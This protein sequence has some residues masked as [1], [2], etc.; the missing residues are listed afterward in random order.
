MLIVGLD[1]ESTGVDPQE[2]EIIEV[3]AVLWDFETA[4]PLRIV[5]DLVHTEREITPEIT[6][7]TGISRS[8]LTDHGVPL[9]MAQ[10][11]LR[12]LLSFTSYVMAHFGNDFD[13]P[14]FERHIAGSWTPTIH[15]LDSATDIVYPCETRK[16]SYLAAEHNFLNPFAHRAVFD[17]L[18]MLRIASTYNIDSIIARAQEPTLYVRAIVSFDEKDKAKERGFRWCASQKLWWRSFKQSD[19]QRELSSNRFAFPTALLREKP[20]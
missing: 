16:L 11:H 15:W 8:I 1:F 7:I 13:R 12:Q 5:S 10:L 6:R 2:D 9:E 20:E 3:G 18:T 4:T 19:Y 14:L 17:V